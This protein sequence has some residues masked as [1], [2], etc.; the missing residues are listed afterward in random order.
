MSAHKA[1]APTHRSDA[2]EVWLAVNCQPAFK[3]DSGNVIQNRSEW[4]P[5]GILTSNSFIMLLLVTEKQQVEVVVTK[6]QIP[7]FS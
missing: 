7:D 5:V 2:K 1:G 6:N 3:F 4:L